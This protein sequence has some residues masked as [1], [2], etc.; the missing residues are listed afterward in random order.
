ML[1]IERDVKTLVRLTSEL[2]RRGLRAQTAADLDEAL[3]TL[4][5]EGEG[6][7]LVLLATQMPGERTCDTIR[8]LLAA[9]PEP[10]PAV[11]LLHQSPD[12][13][14]RLQGCHT[15]GT[16]AW[17]AT[18]VAPEALNA[19]LANVLGTTSRED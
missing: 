4:R 19:L 14:P 13:D 5:D 17:L 16:L 6:C 12:A 18:P 8:A 10:H 7:A 3:E 1:I 9:T 15:G 2:A 11:A